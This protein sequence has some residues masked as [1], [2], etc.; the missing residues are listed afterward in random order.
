MV[1]IPLK[2][3]LVFLVC[4]NKFFNIFHL[5]SLIL[6]HLQ[7]LG[8]QAVIYVVGSV[9]QRTVMMNMF[10]PF[11]KRRKVRIQAVYS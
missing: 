5:I 9:G 1:Q 8:L 11:L 2:L 4:M 7:L 10:L 6:I 3:I